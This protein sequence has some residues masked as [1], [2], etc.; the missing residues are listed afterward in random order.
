MS[1]FRDQ[2][3]ELGNYSKDMPGVRLQFEVPIKTLAP[4]VK[5]PLVNTN[6]DP[7]APNVVGEWVV[8]LV[9]EVGVIIQTNGISGEAAM[10]NLLLAVRE[11]RRNMP[12]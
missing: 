10:E 8:S 3:L 12:I 6:E 2:L 7:N 11:R 9:N 1:R 5:N 4:K